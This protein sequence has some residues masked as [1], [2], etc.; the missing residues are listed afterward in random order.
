[1]KLV[2][3]DQMYQRIMPLNSNLKVS[4]RNYYGFESDFNH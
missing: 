3:Q 4:F 1:M 2:K